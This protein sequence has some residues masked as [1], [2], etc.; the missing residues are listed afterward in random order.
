MLK[1]FTFK[2]NSQNFATNSFE[3]E[4]FL[5]LGEVKHH[6]FTEKT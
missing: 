2:K 3:S 6:I 5:D 4:K 1:K